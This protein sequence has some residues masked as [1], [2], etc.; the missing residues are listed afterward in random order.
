MKFLSFLRIPKRHRRER[1]KARS[2]ISPIGGQNEAIPAALRPAES[3]PDLGAG[4]STL[5]MPKPLALRD[6]E[7]NGM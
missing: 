4:T 2:E 1:S 6:Q 7:S 3:T 5:P